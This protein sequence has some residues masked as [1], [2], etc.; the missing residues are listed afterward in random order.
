MQII[1]CYECA[2]WQNMI[3]MQID[4][5]SDYTEDSVGVCLMLAVLYFCGTT[6]LVYFYSILSVVIWLKVFFL[7]LI[8]LSPRLR[9]F[10]VYAGFKLCYLMTFW[11]PLAYCNV[12]GTGKRNTAR[13]P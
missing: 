8:F 12:N 2:C 7:H 1:D 9:Q 13:L 11:I 6:F 10:N 4:R 3:I 5:L